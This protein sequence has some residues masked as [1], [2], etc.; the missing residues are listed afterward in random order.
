MNAEVDQT[1]ILAVIAGMAALNFF[2]RFL[3]VAILSR[4]ELPSPVLRWL[5][6]VPISV[7]GAL[8]ATEVLS[9]RGEW[10]PLAS[11]AGLPAAILTAFV[12]RRTRSFLGA[13]LAGIV[14]Y[15][16]LDGVM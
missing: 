5:S 9:P 16:L 15:V 2:V 14:C 1:T 11:N 3:P 10:I 4:F 13:T 8:V 7:M 12:F 6:Y